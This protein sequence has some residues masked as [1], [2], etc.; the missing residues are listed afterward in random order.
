MCRSPSA[1]TV[2]SI[3]EWRAS[4]SSMWSKKP[5]PVLTS[6]LPEPSRSTATSILVSLVLRETAPLRMIWPSDGVLLGGGDSKPRAA[7]PP[8]S[9]ESRC[10]E[11]NPQLLHRVSRLRET[12]CRRQLGGTVESLQQPAREWKRTSQPDER[13]GGYE[14][15]P[16]GGEPGRGRGSAAKSPGLRRR[17]GQSLQVNEFC[18]AR[19]NVILGRLR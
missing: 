16:G 6:D 4:W 15:S 11:L 2:R 14:D 9:A 12:R 3:S 17:A 19:R 13:Q 5:T 7:W 10:E 8:G 18:A 1:R